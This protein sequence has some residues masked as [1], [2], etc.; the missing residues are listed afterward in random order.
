MSLDGFNL[1]GPWFDN[2]ESTN[3]WLL[4]GMPRVDASN[5]ATKVV[6]VFLE[7]KDNVA[8][9]HYKVVTSVL[10]FVNGFQDMARKPN[11]AISWNSS[12]PF[13]QTSLQLKLLEEIKE[14]KQILINYGSKHLVKPIQKRGGSKKVLNSSGV[15]GRP[16]KKMRL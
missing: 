7:G 3:K 10:G 2:I 15:G 4:T 13:G 11:V 9:P 14:G 5:L 16:E 6:E 1:A 8:V 12:A